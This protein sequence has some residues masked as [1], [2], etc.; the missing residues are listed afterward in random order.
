MAQGCLAKTSQGN[1]NEVNE[2]VSDKNVAL[3]R[4]RSLFRVKEFVQRATAHGRLSSG[5]L[6]E[7]FAMRMLQTSADQNRDNSFV[8]ARQPKRTWTSRKIHNSSFV[9]E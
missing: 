8:R 1:H 5:R 4:S 9:R 3:T 6:R 7:D 2:Y